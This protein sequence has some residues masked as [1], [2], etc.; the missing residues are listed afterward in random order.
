MEYGYGRIRPFAVSWSEA[1]AGYNY[2]PHM[3]LAH[4][5]RDHRRF[6]AGPEPVRMDLTFDGDRARGGRPAREQFYDSRG[7]GQPADGGVDLAAVE[8]AHLL[9][10]GDLDTVRDDRDGTQLDFEGF[11]ALDSVSE[12]DFFV[13]KD[14]RDRGFYLSTVEGEDGEL[15]VYPR[16]K[17]PWDDEIAYHVQAVSERADVAATAV[18]ELARW[19]ETGVLAVVDEESEVSYFEVGEPAVEGAT[20]HT[21]PDVTG[22]LLADR[23]L[24]SDPPT[25]LHQQA[26]YGQPLDGTRSAVQLSLVEAAHLTREETLSLD[27]E[28]RKSVVDRGRS[29]EGER[30]DRRLRV[31]E[32]LRASGVVPKTGFKFGADFRTYANVESVDDLGHSEYLVRVLPAGHSFEP[33]DLALDVRLAHGVRK[34]MRFGLVG[35]KIDWLAVTRL[36]P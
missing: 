17:G 31:Y 7:Y 22:E 25:A 4:T 8:A 36:T 18:Q 6:V 32:S 9:Y 27:G 3:R 10:R 33:R 5:Y 26:F 30:F 29:V 20:D 14:L 11:L 28:G 19:P 1:A 15:L 23:V 34:E 13:Y 35:E 21:I 16:G 12:V 24:V 2:H